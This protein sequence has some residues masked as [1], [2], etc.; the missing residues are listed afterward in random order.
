MIKVAYEK[1]EMVYIVSY[2]PKNFPKGIIYM[3]RLV[4][5]NFVPGRPEFMAFTNLV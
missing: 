4:K 2:L 1:I 3:H 5:K